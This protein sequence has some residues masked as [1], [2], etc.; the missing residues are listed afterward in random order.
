MK[1]Q[2]LN[3][4]GIKLLAAVLMLADHIGM[5]FFPQLMW[6]RAIG[7]IS[8]P[9][10]AYMLAE[11]CRYTKNK[12]NHVLLLALVA[13]ACQIVYFF[14]AGSLQMCILVT[15]T[16]ST[17][18]TYALQY[19]KRCLF[20]GERPLTTVLAAGGFIGMVFLTFV[21]NSINS[22]NGVYFA[23]EYG[24]WGCMLPVFAS[25]FDFRGLGESGLAAR[26]DNGW[27]RFFSFAVGLVILCAFHV[28]HL[29]WFS[30]IG[31]V[32]LALYNGQS[33]K[34]KLKYF[35]YIFY[36]AHLALFYLIATLI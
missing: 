12:L 6:L 33:G 28:S 7:R 24:F 17:L 14:A 22:I 16:L 15:F 20:I 19:F 30:L 23:I 32:P 27:V 3:G 11:G 1:V 5:F 8:L 18:I 36:P 25:V 21:L 26:L 31:L 9:L 4:N 13:L 34:L 10:F 35:F 2:F 29:E